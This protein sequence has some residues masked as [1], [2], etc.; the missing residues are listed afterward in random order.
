MDAGDMAV[1]RGRS[2]EA[3]LRHVVEGH[4]DNRLDES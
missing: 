3:A 1:P 2:V 4:A